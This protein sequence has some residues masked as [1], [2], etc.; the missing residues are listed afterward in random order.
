MEAIG[1]TKF[2]TALYTFSIQK[3]GGLQPLKIDVDSKEIPEQY[4]IPQSPKLDTAAIREAL[5]TQNL[6]WAHLEERKQ[7]LRIK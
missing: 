4:L 2:S 3:S 7:T 6:Y 1:K 5:K